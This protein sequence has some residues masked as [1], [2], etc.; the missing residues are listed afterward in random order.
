MMPE[1]SR[2]ATSEADGHLSATGVKDCQHGVSLAVIGGSTLPRAEVISPGAGSRGWKVEESYSRRQV[3]VFNSTNP[4]ERS[5]CKF[6]HSQQMI[7][8][9][10]GEASRPPLTK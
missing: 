2:T 6:G 1:L 5:R 8:G 7:R 3:R 9:V 4:F 10:R